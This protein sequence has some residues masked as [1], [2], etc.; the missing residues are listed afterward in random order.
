[1]SESALQVLDEDAGEFEA[2]WEVTPDYAVEVEGERNGSM[3]HFAWTTLTGC[4]C[5]CYECDWDVTWEFDGTV[6]ADEL[7]GDA[8]PDA[9]F[10]T[11]QCTLARR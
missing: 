2:I 8:I 3:I 6:H 4:D 10:G 5:G 1:M 11:A 9:P 7:V